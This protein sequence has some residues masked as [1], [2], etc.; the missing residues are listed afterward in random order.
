[1]A[2]GG[3]LKMDCICLFFF[4]SASLCRPGNCRCI[5]ILLSLFF[6]PAFLCSDWTLFAGENIISGMILSDQKKERQMKENLKENR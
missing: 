1:M 6:P 4:S 2:G 5:F 3:L